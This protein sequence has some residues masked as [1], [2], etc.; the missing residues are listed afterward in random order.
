MYLNSFWSSNGRRCLLRWLLWKNFFA[1]IV[2]VSNETLRLIFC[3][4]RPQGFIKF[5]HDI[6]SACVEVALVLIRVKNK[7]LEIGLFPVTWYSFICEVSTLETLIYLIE[8]L[9]SAVAWHLMRWCRFVPINWLRARSFSRRLENLI[10]AISNGLSIL[11]RHDR[12][13]LC[14]LLLWFSLERIQ[15]IIFI[16]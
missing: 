10:E 15:D 16:E 2:V 13:L 7:A 12:K 5:L 9:G 1:E 6:L 4:E 8:R 14:L 3:I 11:V